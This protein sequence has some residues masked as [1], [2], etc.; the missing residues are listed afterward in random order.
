[1]TTWGEGE[2][3]FKDL[4]ESV[5]DALTNEKATREDII[6]RLTFLVTGA[7]KIVSDIIQDGSRMEPRQNYQ[8]A[9]IVAQEQALFEMN[10]L[11]WR[12]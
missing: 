6:T 10:V 5:N 1:M 8:H 4:I 7:N 11:D 12:A 3:L 9:L 2:F